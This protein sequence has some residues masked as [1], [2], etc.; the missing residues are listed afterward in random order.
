[1]LVMLDELGNVITVDGRLAVNI[2]LSLGIPMLVMLD[3]LGNVITVEGRLAV[4]I[5]SIFRYSYVGD[6]G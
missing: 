3:E 4:N 2:F 6:V 1:M 5:F